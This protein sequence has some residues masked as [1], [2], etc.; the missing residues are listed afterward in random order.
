MPLTVRFT[1]PDP[2]NDDSTIGDQ[3]VVSVDNSHSMVAEPVKM[4]ATTTVTTLKVSLTVLDEDGVQAHPPFDPQTFTD[5]TMPKSVAFDVVDGE[6]TEDQMYILIA[7]AKLT[8]ETT[9]G[10]SRTTTV[11]YATASL[12]RRR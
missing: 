7:S 5:P 8:T 12:A 1:D 3:I 2:A 11:E 4:A 6:L 9:T 10:G